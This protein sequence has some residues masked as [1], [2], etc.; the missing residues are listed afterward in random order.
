M[1]NELSR[2]FQLLT[3]KKNTAFFYGFLPEN[4]NEYFEDDTNVDLDSKLKN[5]N[6]NQ[7]F[8]TGSIIDTAQ[9]DPY[10][11]GVELTSYK[12]FYSGIDRGVCKIH[13][14]EPGHVLRKNNFGTDRNFRKENYY[15]DIEY[16][17]A[18][19]YLNSD[20][21][22]TYPIITGDNSETENYNFN[23]VIEPLTIR[24][25]VSFFSID[26]PFEAHDIKANIEDGNGDITRSHSKVI[27]IYERNPSHRIVPWLDMIDMV[28][29]VKKI[30]TMGFFNDDK[31]FITPFND[32]KNKVELSSNLEG[33]MKT[34]VER[35]KGST[36]NYVPDLYVSAPCGWMYDDVTAKGTDSLAFG[37][38]AY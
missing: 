38:L 16:F 10:R 37:G 5:S 15:Y 6:S 21:V 34:A 33:T 4:K 14:G 26:V 12:Q 9:I 30:P 18:V 2:A 28:G 17:N 29:E 36:E 13:A 8:I 3:P 31:S 25:L 1:S 35:L 20:R 23:G 32:Q 7:Y 19:T 24:A 22:Y 27:S 11:Q